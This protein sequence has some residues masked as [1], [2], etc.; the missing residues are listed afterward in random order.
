MIEVWKRLHKLQTHNQRLQ[1]Q[2]QQ[3]KFQ[4]PIKTF[5]ILKNDAAIAVWSVAQSMSLIDRHELQK[6]T[7]RPTQNSE[8]PSKRKTHLSQYL[9]SYIKIVR[10]RSKF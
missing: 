3:P 6:F 10:V 8:L 9:L 4:E 7:I 2:Q 5:Y 1:Q